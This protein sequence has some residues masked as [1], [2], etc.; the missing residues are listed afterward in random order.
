MLSGSSNSLQSV[1]YD[2]FCKF[3]C[4]HRKYRFYHLECM[5]DFSESLLLKLD[6]NVFGTTGCKSRQMD[7]KER[8]CST[9]FMQTFMNLQIFLF[10]LISK[11]SIAFKFRLFASENVTY[12]GILIIIPIT[13][14]QQQLDKSMRSNPSRR[15]IG[16]FQRN[17]HA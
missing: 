8:I 16:T 7:K 10:S 4:V 3:P 11:G 5:R 13:N 1:M 2:K 14:H 9:I 12:C 17:W 15:I 6:A